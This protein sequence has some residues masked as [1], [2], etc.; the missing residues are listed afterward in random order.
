MKTHNYIHIIWFVFALVSCNSFM[1]PNL[2]DYKSKDLINTSRNDFMGVLYNNYSLLPSRIDFTYEAATDNA[3]TNNENTNSSK[4]ARGG[5]SWIANPFGDIWGTNYRAINSINW[6]IEKMVLDFS[7][8]IPTPV[9]FDKDSTVNMQYFYFTLGEAYFL[10]AW[11]QFDLLQKYGGIGEDDNPYG[12]PITTSYLEADMNLDKARNTYEECVMQIA[13][14][15]DSAF[16]YLPLNYTKTNGLLSEGVVNESGHASGI[17]AA[18][19]KART[20]LYAASPAYNVNNKIEKWERAAQ[21][22]AEAIRLDGFND[23]MSMQNY[24]YKSRLNDKA[25]NNQ[26]M[27]FR[28]QI[29]KDLTLYETENYPPRLLGYGYI[30]PSR[31]LVDAFPMSDGYPRTASS[32]ATPYDPAN[33][34]EN[35]DPR[36]SFFILVSGEIVNGVRIDTYMGGSDA[37]GSNVNATR[38][39]YYLKKLLDTSVRLTSGSSTTTTFA[40]IL[41][42]K[43]ELYLNFAEA[44]IHATG[45]P[46]DNTYGYSAREALSKIRDRALGKNKDNYLPTV[47]DAEQFLDLVKNE[48]RIELC[49]EN[50]RFWDLRRWSNGINDMDKLNTPTYSIYSEEPL[51]IRQYQSPYMPLPYSEILKTNQLINNKGWK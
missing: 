38:S 37:Y 19:L 48:R 47:S 6:Y 44:A 4:A 15:C 31:N 26:D 21:A 20:Y 32:P 22:A 42:G 9:R 39:G 43:P 50:H 36:L 34:Y 27:L 1:E 45:N 16:K 10:R 12:F 8:A 25:Y 33:P 2:D 5:I 29:R 30:N 3:V 17:A 28:G 35:R 40:P 18:A 41:L 49:F 14:D 11:F 13:A 51:E 23:L 7:K 46:D 24:F